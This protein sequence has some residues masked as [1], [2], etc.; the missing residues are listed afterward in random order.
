[1]FIN[2][3]NP[4]L[5]NP[6]VKVMGKTLNPVN[7]AS[8]LGSKLKGCCSLNVVHMVYFEYTSIF[9]QGIILRRNLF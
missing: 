3:G 2:R 1:M 6:T 4:T 8:F 7:S 5:N 9:F